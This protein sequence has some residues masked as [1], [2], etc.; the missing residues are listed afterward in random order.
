MTSMAWVQKSKKICQMFQAC[1]WDV[2]YGDTIRISGVFII[3][4]F[5]QINGLLFKPLKNC[6]NYNLF[7]QPCLTENY[8]IPR[9]HVNA[10]PQDSILISATQMNMGIWRDTWVWCLHADKRQH[11]ESYDRCFLRANPS[12][13]TVQ[14]PGWIG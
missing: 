10:H 11:L 6:A 4:I 9:R 13:R 14:Q 5:L 8:S 3:W 7:F 12:H 2:G 1:S